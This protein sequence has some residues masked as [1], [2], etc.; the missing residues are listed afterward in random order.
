MS[1][2]PSPLP[3][4]SHGLRVAFILP[5]LHRVCRGAEVAFESVASEL[6]RLEGTEITLFGSG[7]ARPGDPYRFVHVGNIPRERFEKFPRFPIFRSEYAWEEFTF[8]PGL[9]A[10]YRP[11]EFDVVVTCSYPFVQWVAQLWRDR[12]RHAPALIFVTQNGDHA[13]RSRTSEYKWFSCD[14]LVC[15]NPDYFAQNRDAWPSRLIPNGVDPLMFSPGPSPREEFALPQGAPIAL[16]VSAL[17]AS[18]RVEEGI[19]AAARVPGLHLVVC[20]QGPEREK[21]QSLGKE[22]MPGRF[23]ALALQ[24]S[25]MPRMYRCADLFLHMSLDE[26]SANAYIEALATGLP[27]VTHDRHVTRWTLE[28]TGVLVDAIDLDAVTTGLLA[29]LNRRSEAEM[30]RRRRLA[31]GRFS[32]AGIAREYHSFFREI[33]EKNPGAPLS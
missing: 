3:A 24:R 27:I 30:I 7:E 14:G 26:P 10:R 18:K 8:L 23:H 20:G 17:I 21:V 28:E 13:V 12:K 29:A 19:R 5:G 4:T 33:L 16:M 32:W 22:L 6:A 15:T 2:Q 31:E 25:Q 9:L 11:S 1:H